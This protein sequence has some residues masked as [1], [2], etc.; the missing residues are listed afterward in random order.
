MRNRNLLIFSLFL[1]ALGGLFLHYRI[2]PFIITDKTDPF[3]KTFSF[4]K[5]LAF[6]LPFIDVVLVTILFLSKKTVAYAYLLNGLIVIYGSIL[7]MHFS[8][9][10]MLAKDIP[11]SDFLI[12]S[13]FPDIAINWADFFIGKA[14]YDITINDK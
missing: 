2:H 11:S 7:M 1:L 14:V 3:I 9:A 13:T 12:K 6:I 8:L 5:F 4:T 10:E